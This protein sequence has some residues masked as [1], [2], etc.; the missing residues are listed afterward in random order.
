MR[1]A[2]QYADA[3]ALFDARLRDMLA[4]SD[5]ADI[6]DW[7]ESS[8]PSIP[9][10]PNNGPFTRDS[11]PWMIEPL[12]ACTDPEVRLVMLLACIQV[13]VLALVHARQ[14]FQPLRLLFFFKPFSPGE[15]C[16]AAVQLSRPIG[17]VV[18]GLGDLWAVHVAGVCVSQGVQFGF[19]SLQKLRNRFSN[20]VP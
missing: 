12:R 4:P 18:H 5:A 2:D 11:A 16:V 6:V 13:L 19:L 10:S 20:H 17:S 15:H 8:V 1:L 9:Y 3:L 14:V 7:L